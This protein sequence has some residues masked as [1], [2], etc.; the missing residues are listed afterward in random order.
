MSD[1]KGLLTIEEAAQFLGV[2]KTSL[3]RWTKDGQLSCHRIGVRA[4][5]RFDQKMLEEFLQ[6]RGAGLPAA[7][8]I[9]AADADVPQQTGEGGRHKH[10]CVY[11]RNPSEQWEAFRGYFLD[12]YRANLPT[13]Y[14]YHA[15]SREHLIECVR[16]EGIDPQDAINRGLLRLVSAQESY[17]RQGAFSADFMISFVR[18]I[19]NRLR[20]DGFQKHLIT[21]EMDWYFTDILGREEIHAYES[22]LNKLLDDAPE[23]TIVCQY[24]ITRFNGEGVLQACC[25]HP[26]IHL[27]DRLRP[28]LFR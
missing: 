22:R 7:N 12:H 8:D 11:F 20:A 16:N 17:L 23:V 27:N 2:S 4:E 3:R 10:I 21:G 9:S 15:S 14:L 13:T 6:R 18:L 25:T 24:D 1:S 19:M 26:L 28:G 5:R